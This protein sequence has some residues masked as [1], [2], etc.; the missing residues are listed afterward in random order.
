MDDY[1]E[2]GSLT[3][4]QAEALRQLLPE[5]TPIEHLSRWKAAGLIRVVGTPNA[6]RASGTPRAGWRREGVPHP[7]RGRSAQPGQPTTTPAGYFHCAPR[8]HRSTTPTPSHR[9][10][11]TFG[12]RF[13]EAFRKRLPFSCARGGFLMGQGGRGIGKRGA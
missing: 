11:A 1:M 6:A 3:W 4:R 12:G 7:A 2:R 5:G 8:G 10:S 13:R 9:R